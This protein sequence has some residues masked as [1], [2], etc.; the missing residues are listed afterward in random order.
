MIWLD[1]KD[2]IDLNLLMG[3]MLEKKIIC[4][5]GVIAIC[6][7]HVAMYFCNQTLPPFSSLSRIV[8]SHHSL[9]NGIVA[10]LK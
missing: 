7:V 8:A 6:F 5:L 9:L 10:I 2:C 1:I 3:L 4:A